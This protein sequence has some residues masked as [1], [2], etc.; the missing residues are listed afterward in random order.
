M[1]SILIVDDD[2]A[3]GRLL[4]IAFTQAGYA[5]RTARN[6]RQGLEMA[7]QEP[8]DVAILDVM[9][10]GVHGYELCRRLRADPRTSGIKIV[11]LTARSQPIDREEGLKAGADLFLSKPIMPN[12]LM[13][14]IEGLFADS[15]T[16]SDKTAQGR[17]LACFSLHHSVGVTTVA[18]NLSLA[19]ALYLRAPTSLI[20]ARPSPDDLTVLGVEAALLKEGRAF[21]HPL[22]VHIQ[23]T[24]TARSL[25][26]ARARYPFTLIDVPGE[27][28]EHTW[29][30]LQKADLIFV[31]TTPETLAVQ[32]AR[33]AVHALSALEV[34]ARRIL[35][36]V[37]HTTPRGAVPQD[38]IREWVGRPVSAVIPYEAGM[39]DLR[40][41]GRPL[42]IAR[43]RSPASIAIARLAEY[44]ARTSERSL[45]KQERS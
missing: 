14:K 15:E 22:G 3:L 18:I 12:E 21:D 20:A 28:D 24:C 30:V 35:V 9:M 33:R 13:T 34:P 29:D 31:V 43:P 7:I 38:R 27:P 26:D 39:Q 41:A 19:L 44:L 17:L 32:S 10:P 16:P 45:P 25:A 37:N 42:L 1:K 6:G 36:I 5:V 23:T 8:P 4:D 40:R 2:P 11:F